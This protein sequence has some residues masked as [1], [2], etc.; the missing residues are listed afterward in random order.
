M[1]CVSLSKD[2]ALH[3]DDDRPCWVT[4]AS[5]RG[6][7]RCRGDEDPDEPAMVAK[8]LLDRG[9]FDPCNEEHPQAVRDMLS[10]FPMC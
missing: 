7:S 10:C 3:K 6:V 9:E 8:G 5:Q 1:M 4:L 2:A